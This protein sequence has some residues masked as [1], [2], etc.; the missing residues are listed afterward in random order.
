MNGIIRTAAAVPH[1]YLGNVQKNVEAHLAMLQQAAK[2]HTTLVTFPELSLT[3]YTCGDLFFQKRLQAETTA[4]ILQLCVS[5]P[6]GVVAVVG[7][8]VA[9]PE[10]LYNCAAVLTRGS[11]LGVV[12]K[13]FLPN[14]N[15]FYEKRWFRSSRDL[16]EGFV[17]IGTQ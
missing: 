7:A 9:K 14:Y 5:C 13:T 10:G 4:G 6:E 3:G 17:T 12:P 8:P 2:E 1:L 16:A 11:I 15:E